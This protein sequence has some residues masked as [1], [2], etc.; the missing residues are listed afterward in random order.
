MKNKE[1]PCGGSLIFKREVVLSFA[2]VEVYG[3]SDPHNGPTFS[4]SGGFKHQILSTIHRLA[5][6]FSDC[7][8]NEWLYF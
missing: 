2:F 4:S 1:T 7:F 6:P 5:M 8:L 3:S